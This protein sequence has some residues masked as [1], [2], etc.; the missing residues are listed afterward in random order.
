MPRV[1]VVYETRWAFPEADHEC[2]LQQ[3]QE[4]AQAEAC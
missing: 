4:V 1:R 3:G 2:L